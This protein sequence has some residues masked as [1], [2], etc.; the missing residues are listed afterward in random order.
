MFESSFTNG[1]Y[2]PISK[3]RRSHRLHINAG[4]Q[5]TPRLEDFMRILGQ[6]GAL[7]YDQVQ[8]WFARLSPEPERLK[9][10]GEL[11]VE[12]TRKI[13]RPW[14]EEELFCYRV[15]FARQKAWLW[16]S[17]KGLK[18]AGLNLR[19]Y[20]PAPA[21]L[22][23]LYSVNEVRLLLADRRP[24]DT[25]RSERELRVELNGIAEGTR[26]HLPDAEL[27]TDKGII[28]IETELTI[29]SEKRLHEILLDLASN[30]RYY[31]IWYIC[32]DQAHQALAKE[33][34]KLPPKA[35]TMFRLYDLQGKERSA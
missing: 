26:R 12:R 19:Y 10:P 9:M 15:I 5:I 33:I 8:R 23:H 17:Q 13:L 7:R 27:V 11:S 6:A 24:G 28:A 30:E 18:Y 14:L 4:P 29:K 16:L 32:S 25:W 31:T 20:E 1:R 2:S 21:S 3:S 35:R 34:E 22:P